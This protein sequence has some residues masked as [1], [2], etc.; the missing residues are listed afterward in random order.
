MSWLADVLTC[1]SPDDRIHGCSTTATVNSGNQH[2]LQQAFP[3]E[4]A[5]GTVTGAM[6]VVIGELTGKAV[7]SVTYRL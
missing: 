1:Q 4:A 7:N 2:F 3:A 5:A 6:V